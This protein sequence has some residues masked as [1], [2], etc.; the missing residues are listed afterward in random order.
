MF[1]R[2]SA[3]LD[4]INMFIKYR[5]KILEL[6]MMATEMVSTVFFFV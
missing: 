2:L 1:V 3:F 4:F 5:S 6:S